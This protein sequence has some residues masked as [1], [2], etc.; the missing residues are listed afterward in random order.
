MRTSAHP[1]QQ[2]MQWAAQPDR[3]GALP[4]EGAGL[5]VHES[6]ATCRDYAGGAVDQAF[7]NP[8]FTV[9]ESF[10][11]VQTENIVDRT[12]CGPFDFGIGI[13][14]SE[15]EALGEAAAYG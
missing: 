15:S 9:T 1:F 13:N 5:L 7:Q 10:L 2:D 4:N 12:A 11:T 3:D 14:K 6:T 8:S